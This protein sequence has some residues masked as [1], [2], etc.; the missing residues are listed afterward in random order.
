MDSLSDRQIEEIADDICTSFGVTEYPVKIVELCNK[1]RLDVYEEFLPE[2]VSGLIVVQDQNFHKFPSGRVIVTNLRDSAKRRRFT[3]AHELA[4]YILHRKEDE[5]LYA[6][7][8]AGQSDQQEH[9]ANVFASCILMPKYLVKNAAE[10]LHEISW[11]YASDAELIRY[12]ADEFA[13]SVDAA[14]IRL[15]KLGMLN[16]R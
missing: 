2:S 14:R 5:P 16:K 8:D 11:G 4:H 3:I 10:R 6:H 12:I 1:H 7:R 13:V 15:S 9:E